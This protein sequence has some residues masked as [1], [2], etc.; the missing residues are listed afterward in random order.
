MGVL[1]DQILPG[2]EEI[3]SLPGA[4]EARGATPFHSKWECHSHKKKHIQKKRNEYKMFCNIDSP[5][6]LTHGK[7]LQKIQFLFLL[8]CE[9]S[10][11][12]CSCSFLCLFGVHV[13]IQLKS[14]CCQI[15]LLL[16]LHLFLNLDLCVVLC[17]VILW[18]VLVQI[19]VM[20]SN[21]LLQL[22]ATSPRTP[23]ACSRHKSP[24][25]VMVDSVASSCPSSDTCCSTSSSSLCSCTTWLYNC[26]FLSKLDLYVTPKQ[27]HNFA[28]SFWHFVITL[29]AAP[30]VIISFNCWVNIFH[31]PM[32]VGSLCKSFCAYMTHILYFLFISSQISQHT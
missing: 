29:A 18:V 19:H 27:L 7:L 2:K 31:V 20:S 15:S 3:T 30:W 8:L 24:P 26:C 23:L 17:L 1:V 21:V 5:N 12:C 28:L 4:L 6:S 22:R 11:S 10:V 9:V 32:K 25:D 16:V 13:H 14:L